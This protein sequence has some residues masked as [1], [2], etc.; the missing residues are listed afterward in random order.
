MNTFHSIRPE[1][2][3]P[4]FQSIGSDWML[5][6][7]PDGEGANTMTVGWACIGVLWNKPVAICYVR[8]QRY[9]Y[10]LC[11]AADRFTLANLPDSYRQALTFCGRASG[12][13]VDKFKE[14][15]L[16]C[17]QTE[18]GAPYPAEAT[19]V[20]V[21]RKLYADDL[22]EEAFLDREVMDRSY[23]ARDFHRFY[24]CEI[25]EVLVAD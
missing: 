5:L 11:E 25:E 7:A 9:T 3:D 17:L 22:R 8:P 4:F 23:P 15:G 2:T 1:A 20:L 10:S 19:R 6:T 16:T 14:T 12:R 24:V 21:C 13:D 18:S